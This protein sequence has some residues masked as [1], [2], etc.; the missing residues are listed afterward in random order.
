MQDNLQDNK[1]DWL[2]IE[3]RCLGRRMPSNLAELEAILSGLPLFGFLPLKS[4]AAGLVPTQAYADL[5]KTHYVDYEALDQT[6]GGHLRGLLLPIGVDTVLDD[7]RAEFEWTVFTS[8]TVKIELGITLQGRLERPAV[9][10]LA[11]RIKHL[12]QHWYE[13]AHPTYIR[14]ADDDERE[15]PAPYTRHIETL[16]LT[17]PAWLSYYGPEYVEKYGLDALRA[18]PHHQ[19]VSLADGGAMLQS[20]PDFYIENQHDFWGWRRQV[21]DHLTKKYEAVGEAYFD[22]LWDKA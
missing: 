22:E 19:F 17:V 16:K 21:L 4:T 6:G 7:S 8:G 1:I 13:V 18:I 12:A 5:L 3:L 10:E 20:R 15:G 9:D 2:S 11:E 14:V